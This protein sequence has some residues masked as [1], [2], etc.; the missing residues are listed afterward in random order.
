MSAHV[1]SAPDVLALP[2][3]SL[4][5]VGRIRS[6][7]LR[8]VGVRN[9]GDLLRS[10]PRRYLDRSA[11]PL[12]RDLAVAR[13]RRTTDAKVEVTI[14][15]TVL[16][17]RAVPGR[18]RRTIMTLSDGTGTL[19]CVW[20]GEGDWLFHTFS[21]GDQVAASGTLERFRGWQMTHPEIEQID[22]AS[23]AAAGADQDGQPDDLMHMGRIVP[24]YPQQAPLAAVGLHSRGM[25][26]LIRRTLDRFGGRI[27]DPVP[28]AIRRRRGLPA[29]AD[30]FRQ[31][32]FPDS[33]ELATEARNRLVFDEFLGLELA[34]ARRKLSRARHEVGIAFPDVG[35]RFER[36]LARLPFELTEGQKQ[37]LRE[38][39][40]D[41][42]RPAPMSRLLQGDVGSGKTLVAVFCA[43]M[44]ADNGWQTAIMAPTEV[45]AEQHAL[46]IG[47][48]LFEVSVDCVLITGST[49][50]AARRRALA[51]VAAGDVPVIIGT[52]VL[53]SGDVEFAR[54]GLVIIDEQHR[55][56]VVQRESLRRKAGKDERVPDLLVMTATPIPRSLAQTLYGDLDVSVLA[57]KPPGR[58][59]I[60]TVLCTTARAVDAAWT[61]VRAAAARGE[62]AYVIFPLIEQNEAIDVR[63]ATEG[64]EE[65]R[66]GLLAGC[67]LRLLHGRMSAGNRDSVMQEF[68][69]DRVDVLVSTT[70]IEVGVDVPNA[71]VM[72]VEGAERFGLAQLHQLRGRIGRGTEPSTCYLIPR[73][74][75]SDEARR[76]LDAVASSDDGFELAEVD[77][78]IRG[79]GEFFGT[80]QSGLPEFRLAH[81]VRDA[82]I[83]AAAREE[84]FALVER[85]F[86]LAEPEHVPLRRLARPFAQALAAREKA[87]R[88]TAA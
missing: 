69:A 35:P 46:T 12:I 56:G 81:V 88:S 60:R 64:F 77:L 42:R 2:V 23:E 45:L 62:Q 74:K 30:A 29:L 52:H 11:M 21:V 22:R 27:G 82:A 78:D 6:A 84:A 8:E 55:F 36:L 65:L 47:R 67:R 4:A 71:T 53:L 20:F 28:E 44:A 70:V 68:K 54:L 72:V 10:I 19:D 75:L 79:P 73:G 39:R 9:V 85:D 51:E 43:V 66:A 24:I 14:I 5:G 3:S 48:L 1:D 7:A 63:A 18:K 41:M 87:D 15:G 17:I 40:R 37:V 61:A 13:D 80:K 33:F 38:I 49:P 58:Q 50:Q 86:D 16:R 32:H 57:E 34:L 26:R 25:R 83:L 31:A 59:P 76:R